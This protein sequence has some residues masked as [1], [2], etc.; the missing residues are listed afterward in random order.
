MGGG[1]G[2]QKIGLV[3]EK[4]ELELRWMSIAGH[5][6]RGEVMQLTVVRSRPG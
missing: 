3:V 1:G 6:A 4:L 5:A 2:G